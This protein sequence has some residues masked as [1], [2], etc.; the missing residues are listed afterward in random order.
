M[1]KLNSECPS[2][3]ARAWEGR[4]GK[5]ESRKGRNRFLNKSET[6]RTTQIQ[7]TIGTES[8]ALH[9]EYCGQRRPYTHNRK[10]NPPLYCSLDLAKPRDLVPC[11]P[12]YTAHQQ[13]FSI[14]SVVPNG[15]ATYTVLHAALLGTYAAQ[16]RMLVRSYA[17]MY[18]LERAGAA[19][20]GQNAMC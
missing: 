10:S 5:G 3:P 1:T 9:P 15:I 8:V 19:V 12:F 20:Q 2:S 18:L 13:P 11:S 4:N 7:C 14:C 16:L 6:I 17:W